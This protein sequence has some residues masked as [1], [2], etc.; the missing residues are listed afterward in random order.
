[1][2][3]SI[4]QIETKVKKHKRG[5]MFFLDDFAA[6]GTPDAVKKSLQRLVH[7]ELLVRLANGIYWYPKKEKELYG[8]KIS[9]KPMLDD[10]A[11]A[12]A[13]RDSA[14]IVPTGV[15]ALNLLN[16]STQVP[17]NI[18]Y[19]TDGA[20]RRIKVGNGKGIL[21][22]HTSEVKRLAYKSELLMLIVSAI[23]EIG[24][25]KITPQQLEIIKSHFQNITKQEFE[26]DIKLIPVW[27]RKILLS[28]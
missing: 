12:V 26:T 24:E 17:A 15:H 6:L 7:S 13:K 22:K 28:L 14:R 19:L 2:Q 8:V 18:V 20:P 16:L 3:S 27:I 10:I 25:G 21:F 11:K 5:K 1:M 23:R 4:N 9:G